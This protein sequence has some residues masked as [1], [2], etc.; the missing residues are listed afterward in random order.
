MTPDTCI[1]PIG[2][3][4]L[5]H[6]V[7][8]W[9]IVPAKRTNYKDFS[10]TAKKYHAD[11]NEV[12]KHIQFSAWKSPEFHK[13]W[14]HPVRIGVCVF[15]EPTRTGPNKGRLPSNVGDWDNY[16]K[17]ILD[18]LVYE[19]WL[20]GDNISVV[21]GPDFV[22]AP[23]SL[24]GH[25]EGGIIESGA[26]KLPSWPSEFYPS[27]RPSPKGITVFSLWD[28]SHKPTSENAS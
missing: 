5:M 14:G 9:R 16:T 26:Y 4:L 21:T 22:H 7:I 15:V 10:P 8:P 11:R 28:A 3:S 13:N 23:A 18:C 2:R 12:A 27:M 20:E 19:G 24:I 25:G 1:H 6:C 17:S